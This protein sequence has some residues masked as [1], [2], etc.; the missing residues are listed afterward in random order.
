VKPR[1]V[2]GLLLESFKS[3]IGL[4]WLYDWEEI[5]N[6]GLI[7]LV[8]NC[9]DLCGTG[10]PYIVLRYCE[11]RLRGQGAAVFV[12]ASCLRK[13]VPCQS[14]GSHSTSTDLGQNMYLDGITQEGR[15]Y[16]RVRIWPGSDRS[17]H[18][19]FARVERSPEAVWILY[20]DS[21]RSPCT[22]SDCSGPQ[23]TLHFAWIDGNPKARF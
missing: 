1:G 18:S 12:A 9:H 13:P 10:R 7:P 20:K 5:R 21:L 23:Q 3:G 14:C 8:E 19:A 16:L 4:R 6:S 11:V 22:P 15:C 17:E 2:E